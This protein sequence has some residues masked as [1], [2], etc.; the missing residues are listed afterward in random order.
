MSLTKPFVPFNSS[1]LW[2]D[3]GNGFSLVC[4]RA[5]VCVCGSTSVQFQILIGYWENSFPTQWEYLSSLN[6]LQNVEVRYFIVPRESRCL[7]VT[8]A[9]PNS[10]ICC[11]FIASHHAPDSVY[12]REPRQVDG[13]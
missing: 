1:G 13:H 8:Q 6:T 5:C 9:F 3:G 7:P 11:V 12:S 2:Q 4:L 10:R